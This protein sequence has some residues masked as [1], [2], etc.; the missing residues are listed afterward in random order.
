[1]AAQLIE[2]GL[3]V[4]GAV[5][6]GEPNPPMPWG[7]LKDTVVGLVETVWMWVVAKI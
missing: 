4:I 3:G 5:T 6:G 2:T 7:Q 1:M